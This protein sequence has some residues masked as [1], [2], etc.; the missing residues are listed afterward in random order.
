MYRAID[1]QQDDTPVPTT[2]PKEALPPSF[3]LLLL[4]LCGSERSQYSDPV[5]VRQDAHSGHSGDRL[6]ARRDGRYAAGCEDYL[7]LLYPRHQ[8]GSRREFWFLNSSF[9]DWQRV[10]SSTISGALKNMDLLDFSTKN[11]M[12]PSLIMPRRV[13][14]SCH[15]LL[16]FER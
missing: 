3:C 1:Y 5:A 9:D 8:E 11:T 7:L 14:L 16:C 2:I 12:F 10:G 6:A 4:V 15:G 13:T